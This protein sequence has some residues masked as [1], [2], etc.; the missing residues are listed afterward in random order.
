M[1]QLEIW[2]GEF[3]KAYTN[4]NVVDWRGRVSSFKKMLSG[5]RISRVL[6]IGCNRGHNLRTLSE[7]FSDDV[8]ILGVEPNRYALAIAR[9]A[10]DK[11]SAMSGNIYDLP[12][13]DRYFDLVFTSGVLSH[14]PLDRLAD[15]MRE[16]ARVSSRYILALEYYAEQE[17]EIEYRGHRDLLWKRNFLEHYHA[18]IPDLT[19][20]RSGSW[21][22]E[23]G[24]DR[25]HWW[26]LEKESGIS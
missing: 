7:I 22:K 10:S 20:V 24:F 2:Q 8:E 18:N 14:V 4:R 3:G 23:D 19:L 6:E 25:A 13:K 26:L 17:I 21:A 9:C 11:V 15:A 1:K 5:L 12:F 16:T